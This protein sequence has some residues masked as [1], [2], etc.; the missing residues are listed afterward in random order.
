MSRVFAK[1]S[2]LALCCQLTWA[3]GQNISKD[4]CLEFQTQLTKEFLKG[5]PA[6]SLTLVRISTSPKYLEFYKE[7][8]ADRKVWI[9]MNTLIEIDSFK[10]AHREFVKKQYMNTYFTPFDGKLLSTGAKMTSPQAGSITVINTWFTRCKPCVEEMPTLNELKKKYEKDGQ[11]KFISIARDKK[12]AVETFL[13]THEFGY[14]VVVD[15][16]GK[17]M[18]HYC[19][20]LFPTN[21]VVDQKGMIRY[22]QQGL[23]KIDDMVAAIEQ[24]KQ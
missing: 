9:Q 8:D 21:I 18:D 15:E 3:M 19:I 20:N 22:F 7:Q 17:I 6:D 4:D 1:I 13:K 24:L 2:L 16:K 5:K 23:A 11:V 14:D 10:I 12:E